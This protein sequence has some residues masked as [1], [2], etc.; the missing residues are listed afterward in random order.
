[1]HVKWNP[2]SFLKSVFVLGIYVYVF[3][4]LKHV[5]IF[6][7]GS[8]LYLFCS[9]FW[10]ASCLYWIC[11]FWPRI[12]TWWCVG[13]ALHDFFFLR[14]AN[15]NFSALLSVP[16]QCGLQSI[17]KLDKI[18]CR[19][20]Y[21]ASVLCGITFISLCMTTSHLHVLLSSVLHRWW[22][23]HVVYLC[24]SCISCMLRQQ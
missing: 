23:L 12:C 7:L 20:V 22:M 5:L 17:S 19:K 6:Q 10:W 14:L 1:M 16:R 8:T 3:E 9:V 11:T 4:K 2:G 24:K 15:S 21:S 13:C 18:I